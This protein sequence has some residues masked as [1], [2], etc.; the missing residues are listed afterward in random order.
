MLGAAIGLSLLAALAHGWFTPHSN[1]NL[2]LDSNPGLNPGV[3]ARI[4]GFDI[5]RVDS[6]QLD[7]AG[8]VRVR[9]SIATRYLRLI[10]RDSMVRLARDGLIGAQHLE[11]TGGSEA[12]PRAAEGDE[13]RFDPGVDWNAQVAELLPKARDIVGNLQLLTGE[14]AAARNDLRKAAADLASISGSAREQAGPILAG[15]QR[16]A[17]H[18]EAASAD[19][20]TS[21]AG[22]KARM[23][24]LVDRLD[25][26]LRGAQATTERAQDTMRTV[27]TLAGKL[28]QTLDQAQPDALRLLR[29]GREASEHAAG[30]LGDVRQAPLYQV[31]LDRQTPPPSTLDP[32]DDRV[33]R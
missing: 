26:T 22:L 6:V 20:R 15:V 14:L 30:V 12:A 3:A 1:L 11:F 9:L 13:M 7:D 33:G 28:S 21:V 5:G 23:P 29:S 4:K 2:V 27:G 18:L 19:A 25:S 17:Q 8:L 31:L 32:Y 24:G 16:S 10:P